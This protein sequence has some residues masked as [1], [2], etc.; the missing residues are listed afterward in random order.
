MAAGASPTSPHP[1]M[2]TPQRDTRRA[3]PTPS[4]NSPQS[5]QPHH[6]RRPHVALLSGTAPHSTQPRSTQ[7]PYPTQ[8]HATLPIT[9][10]LQPSPL[11]PTV[12][13][14]TQPYPPNRPT[15]S[16]RPAPPHPTPSEA[17]FNNLSI[18]A[19]GVSCGHEDGVQ[20][21]VGSFCGS[22]QPRIASN[23]AQHK[24]LELNISRYFCRCGAPCGYHEWTHA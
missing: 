19:F 15:N 3:H 12:P 8:R 4:S 22:M 18:Y 9:A 20:Y 24:P 14:L 7:Q 17:S 11:G 6:L 10:S 16:P 21:H 1:V 5:T 23:N 2:C 13:I